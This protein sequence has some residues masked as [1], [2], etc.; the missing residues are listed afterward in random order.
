MGRR[1]KEEKK[2]RAISVIRSRATTS[3]ERRRNPSPVVANLIKNNE[4]VCPFF[5]Y[6]SFLLPIE[7]DVAAYTSG[8]LI[9]KEKSFF[10]NFLFFKILINFLQQQVQHYS[11]RQYFHRRHQLSRV[12]STV[13]CSYLIVSLFVWTC[14]NRPIF[15]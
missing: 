3:I 1:N 14:A 5:M 7:L 15:G 6:G 9:I 12:V 10:F 4:F 8:N 2:K 11:A 13:V